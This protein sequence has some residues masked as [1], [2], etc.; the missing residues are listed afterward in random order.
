MEAYNPTGACLRGLVALVCGVGSS[1][2]D[3]VADCT[4]VA[5][6][7]LSLSAAKRS[8]LFESDA[9]LQKY[10]QDK[11]PDWQVGQVIHTGV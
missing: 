11:H 9:A 3:L 6:R 5:Y 2:R 1:P 4:E 8:M 7:H 10:I